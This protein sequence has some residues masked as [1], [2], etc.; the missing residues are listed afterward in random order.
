MGELFEVVKF[1]EQ[2]MLEPMVFELK[3]KG[4][5]PKFVTINKDIAREISRNL[6]ISLQVSKKLYDISPSIWRDI[7][8][9]RSKSSDP[10]IPDFNLNDY[11]IVM[12]NSFA[13]SITRD[14]SLDKRIDVIEA[15]INSFNSEVLVNEAGILQ[16][17]LRDEDSDAIIMIDIDLINGLYS[18]FS[19]V[20]VNNLP[21]ISSKPVI[22]ESEF[23]KFL[24]SGIDYEVKMAIKTAA[25]MKN[26]Y[27]EDVA[28]KIH[29]SCREVL[30]ILSTSKTKVLISDSDGSVA[31]ILGFE[32]PTMI[33]EFLNSFGM[34]FKSLKKLSPLRKS[35]RC[36]DITLDDM[37]KFL[38]EEYFS[39]HNNVNASVISH[40]LDIYYTR[41]SDI[42]VASE[43]ISRLK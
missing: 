19:G 4:E 25:S 24:Y 8:E 29:L 23:D 2:K 11:N 43:E 9:M 18:V 28:K 10:E 39:T 42:D 17:L 36:N 40:L 30:N 31:R 37:F 22:F 38:T 34:T 35:L 1:E 27:S 6:K 13:I 26:D 14:S 15:L 20:M 21:I 5:D 33:I 41:E 32:D 7:V 16:I 3:N 12:Y